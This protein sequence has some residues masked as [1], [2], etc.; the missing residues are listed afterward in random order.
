LVVILVSR[1]DPVQVQLALPAEDG[2]RQACPHTPQ[3]RIAL[4]HCAFAFVV[5]APN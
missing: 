4:S 1:G 5:S 3:P 2:Q